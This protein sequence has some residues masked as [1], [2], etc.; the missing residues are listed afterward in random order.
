MSAITQSTL[1]NMVGVARNVKIEG[2]RREKRNV[3]VAVLLQPHQRHEEL[4]R[5]LLVLRVTLHRHV[6]QPAPTVARK[7]SAPERGR[8]ATHATP[9]SAPHHRASTPTTRYVPAVTGK[10]IKQFV[11]LQPRQPYSAMSVKLPSSRQHAVMAC[12]V[13]SS[14]DGD[15][16]TSAISGVASSARDVLISASAFSA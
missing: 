4:R 13:A 15:A 5:H 6:I 11:E 2:K 9:P 7:R 14:S 16:L 12:R 10:A 3:E 8:S 1:H